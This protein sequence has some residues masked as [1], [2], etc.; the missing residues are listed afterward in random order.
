MG[1]IP[2]VEVFPYIPPCPS[3]VIPFLPSVPETRIRPR[4]EKLLPVGGMY[5]SP[6]GGVKVPYI[7]LHSKALY[8]NMGAGLSALYFKSFISPSVKV[9]TLDRSFTHPVF[10]FKADNREGTGPLK[11]KRDSLLSICFPT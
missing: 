1:R 7:C 10:E 2:K 5:S 9:F 6:G 3:K 8:S 4:A 11:E